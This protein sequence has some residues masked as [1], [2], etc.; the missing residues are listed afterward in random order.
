MSA[1][2][3]YDPY[4]GEDTQLLVA[5]ESSHGTTAT[6]TR[7]FGKVVEDASLPD[8]EQEYL[9]QRVIGGGRE[10]FQQEQGQRTLQGGSIPV[11]LQ[12][13][14]PVAYALGS[15][16]VSGSSAPYTH[17][18]TV[19]E[20]GRPPTQTIEATHFGRG[21]GPPLVRTFTG[22]APDSVEISMNADDE[23]TASLTYY[24]LG[25]ETDTTPTS[26]ISVPDTNPWLFADASSKLTLFGT[27]FARVVD[28][29]VSINNSLEEG[30]YIAPDSAHPTGNAREA[31]EFTYGPAEYEVTATLVV[32][33]TALYSELLTPTAGGFN[34]SIAFQRGGNGHLFEITGSGCRITDAP[35]DIPGEPGRVE[36]EATIQPNSMTITAES[37]DADAWV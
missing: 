12:D 37:S 5:P 30:R 26:S 25:V 24:A 14:H 27:T 22:C 17:E 32:E 35:H 33:D 6:P 7:V 29:S 34:M 36:V 15:D 2:G 19:K 11:V 8:P 9:V 4:K 28:F 18:M 31:F 13:A 16:T 10:P 21:G 1:T 20:N 23:L 3:D